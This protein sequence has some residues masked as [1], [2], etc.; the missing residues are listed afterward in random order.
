MTEIERI[1][2]KL[3][4]KH[5]ELCAPVDIS[6][7]RKFEESHHVLLPRELVDFYTLVSNGCQ[8]IDGF[9][10]YPFEKWFFNSERLHLPFEFNEYWIWESESELSHDLNEIEN[11]IIELI[12]IGDA[13]SW[14]IIVNGNN[15]GEMWFYTDVGI[16]PAC[17]AMSFL[18]WFEYWLDG[19]TD[20][21]YEFVYKG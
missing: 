6:D 3:I 17:P 18:K 9:Q 1:K 7:I 14:N 2:S 21:F 10:L 12:D 5:I 20:F 11:G 13:Q 4:D 8:M 15:Y 19:G 16:Q